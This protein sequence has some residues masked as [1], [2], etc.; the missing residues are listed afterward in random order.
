MHTYIRGSVTIH[1]NTTPVW[2]MGNW[3]N[4]FSY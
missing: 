3:L 2:R 1:M 4:T